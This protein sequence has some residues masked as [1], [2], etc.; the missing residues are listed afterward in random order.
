MVIFICTLVCLFMF[1]V[2]YSELHLTQR[3]IGHC[4]VI[5]LQSLIQIFASDLPDS[6]ISLSCYVCF[7]F[8]TLDNYDPEGYN[9][10]SPGLTAAGRNPYRQFIPR[11]QSQRSNLIG[12]TSNEGQVSR[13]SSQSPGPGPSR[14]TVVLRSSFC[15][16]VPY[17]HVGTFPAANIV[18][19]TEPAPKAIT[20]VGNVSR[21]STEQDSRKRPMGTSAADVPA[22]KKPWMDK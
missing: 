7:H 21:F 15:S 2:Y 18:I 16:T 10:E 11:V 6:W 4:P 13:G 9:P 14:I 17:C 1:H 12:L 19:Q 22:V 20:P 5:G 3:V 8:Y